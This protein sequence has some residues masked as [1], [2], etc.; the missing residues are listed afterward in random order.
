MSPDVGDFIDPMY[1]YINDKR[2]IVA[3]KRISIYGLPPNS[4]IPKELI[5]AREMCGTRNDTMSL[6]PPTAG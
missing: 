5:D 6:D 2:A 1:S 3:H 4:G